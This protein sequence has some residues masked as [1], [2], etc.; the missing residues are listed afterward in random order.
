[1]TLILPEM[2]PGGKRKRRVLS[3]TV[4]PD[5]GAGALGHTMIVADCPTTSEDGPMDLSRR[6][7]LRRSAFGSIGVPTV[8]AALA[9]GKAARGEAQ[10]PQPAR[11]VVLCL[12]SGSLEYQSDASLAIFQEYVERNCPVRCTRAFIRTESDLPGLD[13]L[14]RSD[15][16]LLFT[17]RLKLPEEQLDHVKRYC[18]RGGP[19][20]ALRTASHAFQ[21]WL[22]LDREVLGGDYQGHYGNQFK[23]EVRIV[24]SAKGHPILKGFAPFVS[25]GSLYKNPRIAPDCHVLL[26][27]AIPG[28]SEPIAWTRLHR[29]GRVF[30]TSLGHPHDF[31]QPGF[32]RMVANAVLWTTRRT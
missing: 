25:D 31:Q 9:H 6:D 29:G 5:C 18:Q 20:V 15:V 19:I 12:V 24:E 1:V 22:E 8:L 13:Q 16:M 3:R 10:K 14:D 23:T 21:T 27:G 2:P 11:P 4:R 7:F 32:L 17:R 26:T 28:H 30:Y